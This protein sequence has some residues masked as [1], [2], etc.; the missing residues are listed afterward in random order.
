MLIIS[1]RQCPQPYG[2]ITPTSLHKFAGNEQILNSEIGNCN[3][4][5]FVLTGQVKHLV[6]TCPVLF[7][8]SSQGLLRHWTLQD[9]EV[10]SG[11]E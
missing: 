2:L 6:F 3:Q 5:F 1:I 7:W 8:T 4:P 10:G 11:E 9:E